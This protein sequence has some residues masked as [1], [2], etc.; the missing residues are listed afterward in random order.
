MKKFIFT[1]FLLLITPF[2]NAVVF[3]YS[4]YQYISSSA[5]SGFD[6]DYGDYD[7]GGSWDDN[8]GGWNDDGGSYWDD[9]NGYNNSYDGSSSYSG[10]PASLGTILLALVLCAAPFIVMIIISSKTKS[11][12]NKKRKKENTRQRILSILYNN[13]NLSP[14]DG[15]NNEQ[16]KQAFSMYVEIQKAWMNRDLTPV[17]HMLTDEIYNMYQ[18]QIETLIKD[19][20]INVMSNFKLI[21][22]DIYSTSK[23]KNIES[24]KIILCVECKDYIKDT[25]T[26][27]VISGDKKA[28]ITYIYELTFL[29]DIG[30]KTTI[31]CPSCGALVKQQM[32]STCPYCG[33]LLLLTSSSLTMSNKKIKH[34]FKF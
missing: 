28:T 11:N 13:Y 10:G 18:M 30:S 26:K 7:D 34:Q 12:N 32:S 6:S 25:K 15:L 22:G 1:L 3:Q 4:N 14:G 8:D 29:K 9:D 17:R 21:C 19:N 27:R 16:V 20:Q 2:L 23:S 33:N 5:D 31:N 24:V